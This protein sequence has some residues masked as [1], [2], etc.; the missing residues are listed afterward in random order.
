MSST[1]MRCIGTDLPTEG[2]LSRFFA[3][4]RSLADTIV[5]PGLAIAPRG[6]AVVE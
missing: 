3:K 6:G 4:G 2:Q 1:A 5:M